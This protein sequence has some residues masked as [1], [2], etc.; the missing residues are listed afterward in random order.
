MR[1]AVAASLSPAEQVLWCGKSVAKAAWG[2]GVVANF[3]SRAGRMIAVGLSLG[4]GLYVGWFFLLLVFGLFYWVF[5]DG[6]QGLGGVIGFLM[7]AGP[8]RWWAMP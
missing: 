3:R 1:R 2:D 6:I 8:W 5:H 4:F 7:L